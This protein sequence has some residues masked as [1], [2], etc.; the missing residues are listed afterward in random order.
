MTAQGIKPKGLFKIEVFRKGVLVETRDLPNGITDEGKDAL[1]DIMFHAA[2]QV[3]T[4]YIGLIDNAGF[5][6]LAD[7]DTHD[8]HAGW[9][10]NTDYDEAT[11]E[12]FVEAAASSQ[13][14][15]NSASV[16]EFTMNATVAIKGMFMA[17][18]ST[19]GSISSAATLWCTAAF[20]SVLNVIDDDLIRVTYTLSVS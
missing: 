17:S 4:W 1:L 5:T 18:I 8:S 14:I 20:S 6:A 2:T 13:S 7:T 10:E 9:T 11:R 15:T 16:A 19:K 12:E 3:T